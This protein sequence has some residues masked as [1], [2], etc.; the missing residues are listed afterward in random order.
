[1]QYFVFLTQNKLCMFLAHNT[2]LEPFLY[3]L[4]LFIYIFLYIPNVLH[5]QQLFV[6]LLYCLQNKFGN[7]DSK[8]NYIYNW[9][10]YTSFQM[11]FF[12]VSLWCCFQRWDWVGVDAVSW[13]CKNSSSLKTSQTVGSPS[14]LW[15]CGNCIEELPR[16]LNFLAQKPHRFLKSHLL[17]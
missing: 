5:I 6:V 12:V 4:Y 14:L 7:L 8:V 16:F 1:M 17:C 13:M 10:P 11:Y 2:L 3:I 15:D 9:N